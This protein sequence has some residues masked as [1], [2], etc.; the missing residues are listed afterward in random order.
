MEKTATINLRIN[1]EVK[2]SAELVLSQLGVPMATAIDIY[3]KQISLTGGIPFAVILPKAHNSINTD[4]M[5]VT[6]IRS[7]LNEGM[8]DLEDGKERP[9]RESFNRYKEGRG[10]EAI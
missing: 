6:Q 9:A 1:P 8:S 3:L 5:S 2:K 10:N 4:Y 7:K